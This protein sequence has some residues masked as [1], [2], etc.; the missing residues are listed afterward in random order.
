MNLALLA[1]MGVSR[2]LGVLAEQGGELLGAGLGAAVAVGSTW[3]MSAR[4]AR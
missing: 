4:L 2:V 1:K 3:V